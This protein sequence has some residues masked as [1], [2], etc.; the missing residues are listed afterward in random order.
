MGVVFYNEEGIHF[1]KVKQKEDDRKLIR[2]L[3]KNYK[4]GY[5]CPLSDEEL[6]FS[7]NDEKETFMWLLDQVGAIAED[8][9]HNTKHHLQLTNYTL[10]VQCLMQNFNN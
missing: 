2:Y 4:N 9:Y 3:V 8:Y 10:T 1:L 5:C 7:P 6:L